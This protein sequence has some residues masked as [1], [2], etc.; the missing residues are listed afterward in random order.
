MSGIVGYLS[1]TRKPRSGML[2]SISKS[3]QYRETDRVSKWKDDFMAISHV[4]NSITNCEPQPIFSEDRSLCIV[5]LGEVFGYEQEKSKLVRNGHKFRLKANDAEFCLHLF[6]QI[7][8]HAFEKLNGSFCMAIYNLITHELLLVSDRFSSY[9]CFYSFTD[10]KTF[11]F[12]TQLSSILQLHEAPRNLDFESIIEFFTLQRILGA[13]TFYK[14]IKLIPPATMLHH[15]DGNTSLACYWE[16]KYEEEN[17]PEEY[18]IDKLSIAL[19]NS[20]E[21]STAGNYR[22]GLLLSGGLDSRMVLAASGKEMTCFTLGDFKNREFRI[23]ERLAEV[24][25]CK[26]IF[27]KRDRDHYLNLVDKAAEIGDGMYSFIHAHAVGFLGEIRRQCDVLLHGYAPEIF[28]R[29]TNLPYRKLTFLGRSCFSVLDKLSTDDLTHKIIDKVKYSLYQKDP[30]Q[31]FIKSYASILE[32]VL[33]NSVNTIL[34]DTESNCTNIYDKFTWLDTH[35]QSRYPSFLFETS[36]R[37]FIHE[38]SILFDNNLLELYL[39]MPVHFRSTSRIW[40]KVLANFNS[41]LAR[42]PYANTGYSPFTPDFLKCGLTIS[43]SILNRLHLLRPSQLADPTYS[44]GSWPNWFNL[45]RYNEKMRKMV[46]ATLRDSECID[47]AIFNIER[48][49]EMFEE[50]LDGDDDNVGFIFLLLTF[51]R[52][53]KKYGPRAFQLKL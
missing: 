28:F 12:G 14:D 48:V 21:R 9:P 19:R 51:G 46:N 25:G 37:A 10:K 43:R 39:K 24:K 4:N 26:H 53:Y 29:G 49:Q 38:R 27:L 33:L 42:I 31:L 1:N 23:A 36:I 5:M 18:Y 6:E 17:Q 40:T 47:P 44:E 13:K 7:G 3:I 45:V 32:R 50:Y 16:M 41:E 15:R 8:R 2:D 22:F 20:V 52:W 34:K 30:K 11:I 35:Y